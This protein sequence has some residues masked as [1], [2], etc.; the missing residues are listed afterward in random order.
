MDSSQ[1]E[2]EKVL[3]ILHR[4]MHAYERR[5]LNLLKQILSPSE[6]HVSWGTGQDERYVGRSRMLNLVQRDFEQSEAAKLELKDSYVVVHG[7]CAWLAAEIQPT[8]TIN[9]KAHQLANLRASLFLI[10]EQNGWRI[11]HMHGSWPFAQQKE[12]ASFPQLS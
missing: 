8:I 12:G 11:E 3:D 2:H 9:K 4:W 6:S 7:A 10:K 5:D 1:I